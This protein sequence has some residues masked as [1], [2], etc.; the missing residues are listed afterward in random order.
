MPPVPPLLGYTDETGNV[1]NQLTG[2]EVI[3]GNETLE[4]V[5]KSI[6]HGKVAQT[7]IKK[8]KSDEKIGWPEAL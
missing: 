2:L 8:K 6:Y 3:I 7:Q 5:E 1:N 4:K